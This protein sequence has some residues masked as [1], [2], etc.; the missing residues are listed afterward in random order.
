MDTKPLQQGDYPQSLL[1]VFAPRVAVEI[2]WRRT[3]Q[4]RAQAQADLH[5]VME[6]VPDIMFTLDT[7]GNLAKWNRRLGDVTGYSPEEMLNKPALAFVLLEEQTRTADAIQ[8]SFT[9]G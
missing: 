4:E 9:E 3:E 7:Q 2:E 6:T 1:G 8:Q 5:N